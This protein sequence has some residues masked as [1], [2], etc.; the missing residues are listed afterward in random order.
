MKIKIE[1]EVAQ[2]RDTLN[3]VVDRAKRRGQK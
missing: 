2:L 1:T 3:G